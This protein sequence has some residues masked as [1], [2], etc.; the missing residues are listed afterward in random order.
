[1][2]RFFVGGY[3]L[4]LGVYPFFE[5]MRLAVSPDG[6]SLFLQTPGVPAQ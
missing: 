5:V 6:D 2:G 4:V 3:R 1:L